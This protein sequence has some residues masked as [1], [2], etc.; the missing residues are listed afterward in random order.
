VKEEEAEE[1][2]RLMRAIRDKG[3]EQS[4][5]GARRTTNRP[6]SIYVLQKFGD[7]LDSSRVHGYCGA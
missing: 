5:R 6:T 4:I 2:R 3:L 1:V 7:S